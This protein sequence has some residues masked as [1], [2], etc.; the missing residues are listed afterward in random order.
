MIVPEFHLA[1]TEYI[2]L[3]TLQF[4][5]ETLPRRLHCSKREIEIR[6]QVNVY[7][8]YSDIKN[9]FLRKMCA[10]KRQNGTDALPIV[11]GPGT[12]CQGK[13]LFPLLGTEILLPNRM[14]SV[15]TEL[16]PYV[17]KGC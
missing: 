1:R 13:A 6:Y 17:I 9:W 10:Q 2:L 3:Q 16:H 15:V 8:K 11:Q 4:I 5:P 12:R 7:F 14:Q